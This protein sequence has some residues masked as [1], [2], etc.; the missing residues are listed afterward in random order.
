[1]YMQY[2]MFIII[3][4]DGFYLLTTHFIPTGEHL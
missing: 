1:M 3:F 2:F 4:V